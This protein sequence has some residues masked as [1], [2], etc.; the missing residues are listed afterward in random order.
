M[1]EDKNSLMKESQ[2]MSSK[3]SSLRTLRELFEFKNE[4]WNTLQ[5]HK[6]DNKQ[7]V[8]ALSLFTLYNVACFILSKIE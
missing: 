7:K 6:A 4:N 3:I 2:I 1:N 8:F 5:L